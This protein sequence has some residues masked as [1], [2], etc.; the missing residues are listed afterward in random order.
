MCT[1][2]TAGPIRTHNFSGEVGYEFFARRSFRITRLGRGLTELNQTQLRTTAIVTLWDTRTAKPLAALEVGRSTTDK[3]ST[4]LRNAK[5][6]VSIPWGRCDSDGFKHRHA[7]SGRVK[8]RSCA[9]A[10]VEKE[11]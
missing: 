1:N 8:H 2:R 11:E 5:Q 4:A 3:D 9:R 10:G 7:L 6:T